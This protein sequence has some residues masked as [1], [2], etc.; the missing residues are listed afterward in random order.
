MRRD[1]AEGN[2]VMCT[3]AVR[4]HDNKVGTFIFD[5]ARQQMPGIAV[6]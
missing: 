2:I 6:P 5:R 3:V 1:A 4:C